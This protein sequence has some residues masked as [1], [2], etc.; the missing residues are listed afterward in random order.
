MPSDTANEIQGR[1]QGASASKIVQVVGGILAIIA[2]LFGAVSYL[3]RLENAVDNLEITV[4]ELELRLKIRI[5]ELE[6]TDLRQRKR[7]LERRSKKYPEDIDLAGDLK[8]V[9]DELS[10]AEALLKTAI[11]KLEL[12]D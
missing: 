6:K 9:S 12:S 4:D 7:D 8:D 11:E 3:N 2:V 5:L 10:S 1:N